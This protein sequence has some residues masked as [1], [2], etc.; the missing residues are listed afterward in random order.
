MRWGRWKRKETGDDA[1]Y[2][3]GGPHHYGH[4]WHR[5]HSIT[6][7][8]ISKVSTWVRFQIRPNNWDFLQQKTL[9]IQKMKQRRTLQFSLKIRPR[10][11]QPKLSISGEATWFIPIFIDIMSATCCQINRAE[12]PC[13]WPTWLRLLRM[14]HHTPCSSGCEM[15]L[16]RW[17]E[18]FLQHLI[19]LACCTWN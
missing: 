6:A 12:E 2:D 3:T 4:R 10:S 9:F 13:S 16:L 5:W 8:P 18:M 11:P 19:L 14:A 15:H 1:L 17:E 7:C